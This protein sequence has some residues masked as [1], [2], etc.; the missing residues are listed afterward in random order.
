MQCFDIHTHLYLTENQ[1][2]DSGFFGLPS[3]SPSELS[4]F[5]GK[6]C[7]VGIHPWNLSGQQFEPDLALLQSVASDQ[8][9]LA[10]G[11]CGLD[12]VR[13]VSSIEK[14][15][16]AFRFQVELSE[17]LAKPM[18]LHVVKQIDNI[19]KIRK[20]LRAKQNWMIHG[21][22][23]GPVQA[24]QLLEHGFF[25]S[26]GIDSPAQTVNFMPLENLLIESD[27]KCPV[28]DVLSRVAEIKGVDNTLLTSIVNRNAGLFLGLCLHS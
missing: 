24:S 23:G 8:R 25:L 19:I 4:L 10:I 15:L 9:V 28:N 1:H 21:F 22:R 2:H 12:S 18:I 27:G 20:E 26:L 5:S 7:S 14:Q 6:C 11:E 3:L 16:S 13:S 17:K